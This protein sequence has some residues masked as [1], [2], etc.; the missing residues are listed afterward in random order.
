MRAYH[1]RCTFLNPHNPRAKQEATSATS[2]AGA[3]ASRVCV[4][5]ST[6]PCASLPPSQALCQ[7]SATQPMVPP[8]NDDI[9][10][11]HCRPSSRPK[12]SPK[13]G[14]CAILDLSRTPTLQFNHDTADADQAPSNP[15][16][17]IPKPAPAPK[18]NPKHRVSA[19]RAKSAQSVSITSLSQPTFKHHSDSPCSS[20]T[21]SS[22]ATRQLNSPALASQLDRK[23]HPNHKAAPGP[24]LNPMSQPLLHCASRPAPALS[25][26]SNST[27]TPKP[28]P[29]SKKVSCSHSSSPKSDP[30]HT[31][32]LTPATDPP[33][34]PKNKPSKKHNHVSERA[35]PDVRL[36]S[37]A[38]D[39][40][41]AQCPTS[42]VPH[43]Q[44][45]SHVP[46]HNLSDRAAHSGRLPSPCHT[47]ASVSA[48]DPNPTCTPTHHRPS[49]CEPTPT[50]SS[51]TAAVEAFVQVPRRCVPTPAQ[52]SSNPPQPQPFITHA[53]SS[54]MAPVAQSLQGCTRSGALRPKGARS[55]AIDALVQV[56]AWGDKPFPRA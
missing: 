24:K 31:S 40:A 33:R 52:Q 36:Q 54:L 9:D 49:S 27:S 38:T 45:T 16:V 26:K 19:P 44:G 48:L 29:S 4:Q 17:A 8:T 56:R 53:G 11:P 13:P 34:N 37:P 21:Q 50:R 20:E 32:T 5:P 14:D 7:Q 6:T 46:C 35:G 47:S 2:T 18:P 30:A 42:E 22:N 12:A 43:L 39:S 15:S 55:P 10:R 25:P 28:N 51:T 41:V 1:N 3:R 23:H